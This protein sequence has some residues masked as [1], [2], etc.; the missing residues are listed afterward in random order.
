MK[1]RRTAC[2]NE[3]QGF[4]HRDTGDEYCASCARKVNEAC[5]KTVIVP[6]PQR[7]KEE[8]IRNFFE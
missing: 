8:V 4:I 6:R 3:A 1:C 2:E 7:T 5:G